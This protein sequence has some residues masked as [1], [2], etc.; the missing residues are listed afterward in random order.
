M[1][2]QDSIWETLISKWGKKGKVD[3]ASGRSADRDLMNA[4]I[5]FSL[6]FAKIFLSYAQKYYLMLLRQ[7]WVRRKRKKANSNEETL[8]TLELVSIIFEMLC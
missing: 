2:T 1:Y 8:L 6:G 4:G 7:G 5:M 3:A